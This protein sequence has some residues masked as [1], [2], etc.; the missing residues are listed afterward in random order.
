MAPRPLPRLRLLLHLLLL[1]LLLLLVLQVLRL[2]LSHLELGQARRACN[3]HTHP[4]SSRDS[5]RS[6]SE[7]SVQLP[8]SERAATYDA[9][10]EPYLNRMRSKQRKQDTEHW[11]G[12]AHAPE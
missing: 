4:P 7:M 1:L 10:S 11:L 12:L 8:Q 3:R 2:E 9:A 6:G 5:T